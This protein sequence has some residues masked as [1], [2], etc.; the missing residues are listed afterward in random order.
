MDARTRG[1]IQ[2]T[3]YRLNEIFNS[4]IFAS[5]NKRHVL[6]QSALLETLVLMRDLMFKAEKHAQRINFTED[7]VAN[8][9]VKDVSDTVKATRDALCHL[10]SP[11]SDLTPTGSRITAAV[12]YGKVNV[13]N[14]NGVI[15][16]S[17]YEDDVCFF[18]G[19]HKL[20]LRRHII[21][22]YEEAKSLLLPPD[23]HLHMILRTPEQLLPPPPP[24]ARPS[25]TE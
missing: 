17:D 23:D 21:R 1:E 10:N 2:G 11:N 15:V 3:F 20:Y 12:G 22:A 8:K 6:R 7:I 25:T 9:K 19:I 14:F 13:G 5:E 4:N 16:E 18:F 24:L